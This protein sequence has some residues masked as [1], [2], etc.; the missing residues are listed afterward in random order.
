MPFSDPTLAKQILEAV[1]AGVLGL[2]GSVASF[3]Y[4]IDRGK[5]CFTFSSMF[6]W[7][8]I[9]FVVGTMIGSFVPTG[10][11]WYGISTAA[12]VASSPIMASLTEK[13]MPI[14]ERFFKK[15]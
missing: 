10:E 7:S 13:V 11:N 3:F 12:G 2:L 6:I 8:F 4:Q 14:I 15:N 1:L 5:R 9:G